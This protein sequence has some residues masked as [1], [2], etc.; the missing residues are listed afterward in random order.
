MFDYIKKWR[1]K[2]RA[3]RLGGF[4]LKPDQIEYGFSVAG[5]DYY[6]FKKQEDM[7]YRRYAEFTVKHEE[8]RMGLSREYMTKA[9][10]EMLECF[11]PTQAGKNAG[12]I[13]LNKLHQ[14]TIEMSARLEMAPIGEDVYAYLSVVYF[15]LDEDITRYDPMLNKAKIKEWREVSIPD[16]FTGKAVKECTGFSNWSSTDIESFF[17]KQQTELSMMTS[18][19]SATSNPV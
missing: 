7:P 6:R 9:T 11:T 10:R 13:N 15:T 16:F 17:L 3:R 19:F 1:A 18:A 14:I 8:M 12:V 4:E 2:R 5:K